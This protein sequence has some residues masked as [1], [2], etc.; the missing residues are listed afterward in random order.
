MADEWKEE[1]KVLVEMT[2]SEQGIW[3]LN[4]F[5]DEVEADKED[6][7]NMV[8]TMIEIE[9]GAPKLYGRKKWEGKEGC[10]LDQFQAHQFLEKYGETLTVKE[11]SAKL[12]KI[13]IDNNKKMCLTEYL[14]FKYSKDG[15]SV[16]N[17]PQGGGDPEEF[18][19]GREAFN[20]ARAAFSKSNAAK[21]EA[22]EALQ[23]VEAE[24]K[25][26]N[27]KIQKL[28]NKIADGNAKKLSAVKLGTYKN[29]LEQLKCQDPLPLS[30]AR[31]TSK[32]TLKK[33]KK[34][35]KTA[36]KELEKAEKIFDKL[37]KNGGAALG[38]I[39]WMERTL[40]ETQKFSPKKKKK[41]TPT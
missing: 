2:H 1:W 32:A 5:W 39:W 41:K 29:E 10:E 3:F 28:E 24:E 20:T 34:A 16:V 30:K 33:L 6:I 8:H 38:A 36:K 31:L 37:K 21:E 27:D 14:T 4:G 23:I 15:P 13:D 18:K 26:Y 35:N 9:C 40:E 12:K 19:R 7:W 25:A 22:D 11:L 17:S